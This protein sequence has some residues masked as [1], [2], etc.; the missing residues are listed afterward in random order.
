MHV[1]TFVWPWENQSVAIA[2]DYL[3]DNVSNS[4]RLYHIAVARFAIAI[5]TAPSALN[6]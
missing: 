3:A 6:F 4:G 5:V 2:P 1:S